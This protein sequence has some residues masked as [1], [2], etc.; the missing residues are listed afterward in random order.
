MA[1]LMLVVL[2]VGLAAAATG[3]LATAEDAP[4]RRTRTERTE[5]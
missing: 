1:L 2:A 3:F 4:R 5:G